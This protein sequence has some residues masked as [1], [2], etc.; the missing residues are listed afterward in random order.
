MI[1]SILR[2]SLV[3]LGLPAGEPVE[4]I[5]HP[6]SRSEEG[7]V[8]FFIYHEGR[9]LCIAKVP[10]GDD[11]NTEFEA[12]SLR[13]A[14]Q[15]VAGSPI[16]GTLDRILDT[17]VVDGRLVLFKEFRTGRPAA[18]VIATKRDAQVVPVFTSVATW[19]TDYVEASRPHHL[20]DTDSKTAALRSMLESST[21]IDLESRWVRSFLDAPSSFVGPSH[22]DLVPANVL[23]QGTTVETVIDF[24]NFTMTGFPAADL[25]G[26]I[27]STATRRFGR[28][29]DLVSALL[30]DGGAFGA[31]V[32]T[33]IQGYCARTACSIESFVDQLPLYSHRSLSIAARWGLDR[34]TRLHRD[35]LGRFVERRDALVQAWAIQSPSPS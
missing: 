30:P 29:A 21:E 25:V 27:V 15:A 9:P 14:A 22:G 26:W 19:W 17:R 16:E 20:F 5:L 8:S 10:R 13:A 35:L 12:S 3:L 24:E 34:E 6:G 1:Q 11:A 2:E 28:Q 4:A 7:F 31:A 23:M 18:Q 33:C 32:T